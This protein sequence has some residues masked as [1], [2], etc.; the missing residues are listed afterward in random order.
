MRQPEKRIKR[1][2]RAKRIAKNLSG[3]HLKSVA[4]KARYEGNPYH[5][6][7]PGGKKRR[8]PPASE[9]DKSWTEEQATE[10]LR[11][12]IC[13]GLV[14]DNWSSDFPRY[15]WCK[16]GPVVYEAKLTNETQGVYH[17]YPL[18][19]RDEWPKGIVG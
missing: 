12:S 19:S 18:N 16:I 1:K 2:R 14:S 4:A 9:C 17:G 10:Y 3:E 11:K 5:K 7:G 8:Y 15:V 13:F 6:L